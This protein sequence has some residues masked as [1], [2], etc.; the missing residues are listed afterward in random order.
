MGYD[1]VFVKKASDI[2]NSLQDG[3]DIVLVKGEDDLCS[4]CPLTAECAGDDGDTARRLDGLVLE[5][6]G[7]N[8]GDVLD[9]KRALAV[10]TS[11]L[12]SAGPVCQGCQWLELC[13][14]IEKDI[15][16]RP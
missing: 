13:L 12:P 11:V 6:T 5:R 4:C 16:L 2:V 3:C 1:D 10:V 7:F 14:E 8:L 15:P 9:A